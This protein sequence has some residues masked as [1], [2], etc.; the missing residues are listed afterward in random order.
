M[1]VLCDLEVTSPSLQS[2]DSP[3]FVWWPMHHT[4]TVLSYPL[5]QVVPLIDQLAVD[6]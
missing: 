2:Y 4:A 1:P 3:C 5:L 6:T